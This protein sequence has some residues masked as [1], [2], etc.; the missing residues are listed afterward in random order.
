M[1][2]E[3]AG[4]WEDSVGAVVVAVVGSWCV[5]VVVGSWCVGFVVGGRCVGFVVESRCVGVFVGACAFVSLQAL[6]KDRRSTRCFDG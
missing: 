5:G 3:H 1:N 6:A 4:I 2:F